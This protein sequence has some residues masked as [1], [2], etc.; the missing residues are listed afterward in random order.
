[1][2]DYKLVAAYQILNAMA[3]GDPDKVARALAAI[4]GLDGTDETARQHWHSFCS[5]SPLLKEKSDDQRVLEVA[6]A[7]ERYLLDAIESFC[8]WP[9]P[10]FPEDN[11]MFE[12]K[13]PR[14]AYMIIL[15]QGQA[16]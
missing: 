13:A 5:M 2:S 12:F 3:Y 8:N 15:E 14:S 9:L 7:L 4:A 6:L 11:L 10:A 1:M 16:K